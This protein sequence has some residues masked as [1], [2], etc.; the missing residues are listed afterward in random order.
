LTVANPE[1]GLS[2]SG[3]LKIETVIY[4]N[5][6]RYIERK[7]TAL[8]RQEATENYRPTLSSE[9]APHNKT[10]CRWLKIISIEETENIARWS[11]MAA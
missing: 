1:P 10:T 6:S 7:K 2:I 11:Q 4:G 8:I 9:R 5:Q 3:S